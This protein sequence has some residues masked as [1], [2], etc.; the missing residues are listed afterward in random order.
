MKYTSLSRSLNLTIVPIILLFASFSVNAQSYEYD[1]GKLNDYLYNFNNGA[2]GPFEVSGKKV[3]FKTKLEKEISFSV[4]SVKGAEISELAKCVTLY[5]VDKKEYIVINGSYTFTASNYT[6]INAM[7]L[8]FNYGKFANLLNNF[9]FSLKGKPVPSDL[10]FPE[11]EESY[12]VDDELPML[13]EE[14]KTMA[15]KSALERAVFN[16]KMFLYNMP[17]GNTYFNGVEY[18]GGVLKLK[19]LKGR[20]ETINLGIVKSLKIEDISL[21]RP[22]VTIDSKGGYCYY[23]SW[24]D[25]Y[26]ANGNWNEFNNKN[27]KTFYVLLGNII[28]SYRLQHV[29]RYKVEQTYEERLKLILDSNFLPSIKSDVTYQ[30]TEVPKSEPKYRKLKDLIG[31]D[32]TDASLT[33]NEDFK[34]YSGFLRIDAFET[35]L[36]NNVKIKYITDKEGN[37]LTAYQQKLNKKDASKVNEEKPDTRFASKEEEMEFRLDSL[38][39]IVIKEKL[40]KVLRADLEKSGFVLKDQGSDQIAVPSKNISAYG[41]RFGIQ[42]FKEYRVLI[43]GKSIKNITMRINNTLID[44]DKPSPTNDYIALKSLSEDPQSKMAI[45]LLNIKVFK[46]VKGYNRI[47][48]Y[49]EGESMQDADVFLFEKK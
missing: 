31:K 15:T 11:T 39:S 45:G 13:L 24:N 28:D 3:R 6:F 34:T 23:N 22:N 12:K 9:I 36:V 30:L 37:N 17:L 8:P 44:I 25:Y 33:I 43:L 14:A 38:V 26:F 21:S 20:Y 19:F 49:S 40:F 27:A 48:V 46:G 32:L 29:K 16:M 42:P 35:A 2:Y 18:T 5:T 47:T 7:R 10:V 1:L 41:T 4:D